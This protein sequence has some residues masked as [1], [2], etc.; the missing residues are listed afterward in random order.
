MPL[1]WSFQAALVRTLLEDRPNV[2]AK[3]Y[4]MNK[5]NLAAAVEGYNKSFEEYAVWGDGIMADVLPEFQDSDW[6]LQ[7]VQ[8]ACWRA[9]RFLEGLVWNTHPEQTGQF[10][11]AEIVE[12]YPQSYVAR[13]KV[14]AT[15]YLEGKDNLKHEIF[16]VNV[17]T[18]VDGNKEAWM[19]KYSPDGYIGR[20][21]DTV[22]SDGSSYTD[23]AEY[24]GIEAEC[25]HYM[26]NWVK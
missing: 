4:S 7:E 25:F 1:Q 12:L 3:L 19:S 9:I 6:T 16:Q 8:E 21:T 15:N 5:K 23:W 11:E 13:I 26:R 2:W 22:Y 18:D 24:V 17:S 20:L 10:L 14:L